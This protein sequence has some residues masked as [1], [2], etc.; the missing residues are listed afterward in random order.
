MQ[1]CWRGSLQKLKRIRL[2]QKNLGV[3]RREDRKRKRGQRRR[4]KEADMLQH[5]KVASLLQATRWINKE[6]PQH[7]NKLD[8]KPK[9]SKPEN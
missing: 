6:I 3:Y 2:E 7:A 4:S 1:Q 5:R 8:T 9:T